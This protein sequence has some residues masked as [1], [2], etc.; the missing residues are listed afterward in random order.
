MQLRSSTWQ[1]TLRG[2]AVLAVLVTSV[3]SRSDGPL[4]EKKDP[5]KPLPEEIVTAWKK[6]GAEVGWMR[7]DNF[8]LLKPQTEG[9]PGDLPAFGFSDRAFMGLPWE[10]GMLAKLPA[11]AAAFGL[12][13]GFTPVTD[14]GL[15]ELAGLKNLQTLDLFRTAVTDA[16]LKEL[17]VLKDLQTLELSG[18]DVTDLGLKELAA[19]KNLQRLG[20]R[21]TQ[22]QGAG[23]KELAG[24]KNLKA[25]NLGMVTDA[26]LKGLAGLKSLQSLDL[27]FAQVTD[28]GLK[29]LAG[30]KSLQSLA[31]FGYQITD[32]GLKELAGLKNL[33][34]LSLENTGVTDAGLKE[35]AALKNLQTLDL[36]NAKVTDVGLKELAGLKNLQ[37]LSLSGTQITNAGLKELA[38]LKRLQELNLNVTK[39]TDAGLKELAGLKLKKITLPFVQTDL[40]LKHYLAA[41]EP[42]TTLDLSKTKVTDAGLKELA[43][44]TSLQALD[45]GETKVTDAGLKELAGLKTLQT[46]DL[47]FTGVTDMGLKELAGLQ[48]LQTLNLLITR[49]TDAGLKE[50]A[51]LKSLQ[52]LDLGGTKV[53]DAGLKEVAVLKNLQTL[54]LFRTKMT[55]AGL[56]ELAGLRHLQTLN[57]RQTEM[58]DAGWKALGGLKSLQTLDLFETNVTDGGLKELAA[59]KNLQTLDLTETKVTDAGLKG[60][61]GLKLKQIN[62]PFTLTDVGLKHYLAAVEPPIW[63][64]LRGTQVTNA[65]LKELAGLKTLKILDLP[66]QVTDAGLKELAGLKLKKLN[67]PFV[68]TDLGLKHYLAAVE[69]P[70]TLNL[71]GT[72]VTDAGLKELAGL[73][74]LK[75]L[76]LPRQVT[77]AGLKELARLTSLQKLDLGGTEVTDAGFEELR[78]A[79]PGCQIMPTLVNEAEKLFRTMEKKIK[80]AD[81]IQVTV[82]IELRAI[83]GSEDESKIGKGVSKGKGTLLLTKDNRARLRIRNE[84]VGMTLVSNGKQLKVVGDDGEVRTIPEAKAMP[85][86]SHLHGLVSTVVSRVGVTNGSMIITFAPGPQFTPVFLQPGDKEDFDPEKLWRIGGFKAGAPEKVGGRGAKVVS[87]GFASGNLDSPPVTLWIDAKTLLPLKRVVVNSTQNLHITEIYTEFKLDPKVDAKAFALIHEVNDAEKLFRAMEEKIKAAKALEVTFEFTAKAKAKEEK[88]KGSLLFTKDNKA[89]LTMRVPEDGKERIEMVSDGKQMKVAY[90]PEDTLAK[91]EALRTPAVLHKLFGTMVSGPGTLLTYDMLNVPEWFDDRGKYTGP[92]Y[93]PFRIVD[94]EAGAATKVDGRDARVITYRV[95]D[96]PLPGADWTITV[97]ID[98]ET[99]LP[100]KRLL[101]AEGNGG[102]GSI[103]ETCR[104]NLN[105]KVEAGAFVLPK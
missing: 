21:E 96:H 56:K 97:W 74:T 3:L 41:V 95:L 77:D 60:L 66:T 69:P 12:D 87:Y 45:L 82:D 93:W 57:L 76:D 100:L 33:Q 13:L 34:T 23:L 105:P 84:Y 58:T 103:T 62:L 73:K 71:R 61:A 51:G 2:M 53:S 38:V 98:A 90:P 70:T 102:E 63:L 14:A 80:A 67:L 1:A 81:A 72:K 68:M 20:L 75:T 11:P 8:D 88:F 22:V 32:A 26:G 5:P 64:D 46:L 85:T 49:V 29:E 27:R 65:G 86:P 30:L 52:K 37:S 99:L 40:G 10:E 48:N 7:V 17:A 89:R 16:G 35:L 36:G 55:G 104:F 43:G 94:F 78:R 54:D 47:R 19:L 42:P 39:V 18:T 92:G 44:L 91:T 59:L 31:L 15:K 4:S 6:A 9:V 83:K 101:V 28:L 79:L 24:L 25:L 50:L